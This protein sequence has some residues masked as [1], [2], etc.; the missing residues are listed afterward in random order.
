VPLTNNAVLT[1]A[2]IPGASGAPGSGRNGSGGLN[3]YT[4]AAGAAITPNANAQIRADKTVAMVVDADGSSNLTPGDT[5]EWTIVLTNNGPP[6]SNVVFTDSVPTNTTYVASS[7]TTTKGTPTIAL[8]AL[9][10]AVGAMAA[11]EIVTIKFRTAVD[12]TTTAGTVLS[13]QGSVDSDQTVPTPTDGDGNPGNGSQPTTI[14]V[15]GVPALTLTKSEAFPGDTNV[16]GQLNP[17]E[18]IRYTLKVTSTGT[19]PAANVVFTD[20]VPANTTVLTVTSTS[21][22]VV[23][24]APPTVNLGNM[25]PGATATITID[26]RVIASTTPGTVIVN[27]GTVAAQG[28][29]NVPS[30]T[31]TAT[32]AAFPTLRPPTGSK[33]VIFLAPNVL[34]W[35]MV[36]I[37]SANTFPLAVRVRD[38]MPAGVTYMPGT[39]SCAPQGSTVLT[40][41]AFDGVANAVVVEATLGPDMGLTSEFAAANELLI[42]FRTVLNTNAQVVNIAVAY[43]DANG[44]GNVT[45]DVL[46]GQVP[47]G[48]MAQFGFGV[49]PIDSRWMLLMLSA[50]L[51]TAAVLRLRR[52]I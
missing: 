25:P 43:W 21:G 32:V 14:I 6:I 16:D 11:S 52:R 45:D 36:W 15:N 35:R 40:S 49:V 8:P 20:P 22:T 3:D 18:T 26:V 39:L 28:I 1:Y 7:L 51:A 23:A 13:N 34:E 5:V 19:S 29:A 17:G 44:N 10:V 30:N 4:S 38:P 48:A 41:C 9:S 50:L 33:T 2:S 31:V 37:N 12:L 47:L 24:T 27:Q 46:A 42:T